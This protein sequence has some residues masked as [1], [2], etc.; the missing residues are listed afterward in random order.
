VVIAISHSAGAPH[1]DHM[2]QLLREDLRNRL[3]V[4]EGQIRA[5]QRMVGDDLSSTAI[6]NQIASAREGVH[7]V[8]R[9]VLRNYVGRCVTGGINRGDEAVIDE[10]MTVLANFHH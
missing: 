2:P 4:I 3:T 6:L 7:H 9:L 1:Y 8:G 5:M 10:L